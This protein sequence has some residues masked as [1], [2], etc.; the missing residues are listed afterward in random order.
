[1]KKSMKSDLATKTRARFEKMVIRA[2]E[3]TS[4]RMAVYMRERQL[5]REA[6]G[7]REA[8]RDVFQ[9]EVDSSPGMTPEEFITAVKTGYECPYCAT[10]LA[11]QHWTGSYSEGRRLFLQT[12]DCPLGKGAS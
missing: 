11:T 10:R 1:M 8:I 7:W 2:V 5:D 4:V 12:D 3:A 6:P 9:E